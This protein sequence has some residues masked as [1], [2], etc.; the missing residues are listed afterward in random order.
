MT[1]SILWQWARRVIQRS[2]LSR[3]ESCYYKQ[4]ITKDAKQ[5]LKSEAYEDWS[6]HERVKQNLEWTL[7]GDEG[8]PDSE[9]SCL[10]T[11]A[12]GTP[13]RVHIQS[14]F[15][16]VCVNRGRLVTE[17]RGGQRVRSR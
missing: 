16:S 10:R 13:F 11:G 2:N 3:R 15:F 14:L 6:E 9:P 7:S 8:V 4:T 17:W 1:V 5:T 12:S